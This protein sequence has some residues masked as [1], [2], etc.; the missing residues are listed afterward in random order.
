MSRGNGHLVLFVD[1]D[2]SHL[3]AHKP[4]V[5]SLLFET[6]CWVLKVAQIISPLEKLSGN[7]IYR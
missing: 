3:R 7:I 2:L 6:G 5:D 4:T 1:G